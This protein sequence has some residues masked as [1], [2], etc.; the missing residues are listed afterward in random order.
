MGTPERRPAVFELHDTAA[1]TATPDIFG[2]WAT[3]PV[4]FDTADGAPLWRANLAADP[5]TA[6]SQ[7]AGG[8]ALL[9]SS[10]QALA[11]AAERLNALAEGRLAGQAFAVATLPR[12]E[13]ELIDML[14]DLGA[15]GAVSF[16]LG[17][18]LAAGWE[19]AAGRFQGFVGQVRDSI[20]SR[21]R[22]ETRL[23]GQAQPFGR[24]VV[25]WL[26][27]TE[28][29]WAA[30][31]D[32]AQT[33]LHERTITL[34]LRSRAMLLRTFVVAARGAVTLSAMLATPGGMLLA[35]P[36]AWRFI[37]QVLAEQN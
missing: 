1:A 35:L 3:A 6:A 15:G 14:S 21:A 34:A 8:E 16:G 37:N 28:T 13:T 27:D 26:G 9:D 30:G 10:H 5:Q 22:V 24:T 29:V 36:A 23:Q 2:L 12:P 20:A 11:S 19:Q 17:D 33:E 31:V 7:L 25:G 18:R 32:C 4:A